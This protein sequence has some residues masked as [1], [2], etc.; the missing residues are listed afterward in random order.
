MRRRRVR[1]DDDHRALAIGRCRAQDPMAFR[2]FVVRHERMVFALL[3]RM[4]DFA[5]AG[6][7][8]P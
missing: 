1:A 3:S 4:L 7:N 5:E 8:A 2:A 6:F